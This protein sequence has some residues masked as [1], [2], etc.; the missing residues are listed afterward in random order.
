[1]QASTVLMAPRCSKTA[2]LRREASKNL[3]WIELAD[4]SLRQGSRF[5]E[6]GFI[7]S[8]RGM[9]TKSPGVF[10]AGQ[11]CSRRVRGVEEAVSDGHKAASLVRNYLDQ[12]KQ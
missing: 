7:K 2:I 11:A 8:G 6:K 1:M 9:Q 10:A 4:A 5:D 3:L 12:H